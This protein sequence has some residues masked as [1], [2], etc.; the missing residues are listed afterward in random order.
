MPASARGGR[1]RIPRPDSVRDGGA[2]PWAQLSAQERALT[3][4]DVRARFADYVPPPAPPVAPGAR[5]SA[6]LVPVFEAG[7]LARV[8]FTKRPETMPHHQGEIAFPGGKIEA[9]LDLT[10]RDAALREAEEEIGLPRDHVDVIAA[11]PAL[12]SVA[13]PFMIEPF[14]GLLDAPPEL[15]P[16]PREVDRVFDIAIADL[17]SAGVFWEERWLLDSGERVMPFY[18]VDHETVWGAT[19]RI[20]TNF[21]VQ[22]AAVPSST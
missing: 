9:G 17:L 13:G 18:E 22:V 16:D 15:R 10:A 2:A 12:P 14:V 7:G 3:V 6:V 4:D 1:Q 5:E 11:L 8:V 19:A 20:L 21:L